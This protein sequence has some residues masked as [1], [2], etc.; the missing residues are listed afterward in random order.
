MPSIQS[1]LTTYHYCDE[2]VPRYNLKHLTRV[3]AIMPNSNLPDTQFQD[4]KLYKGEQ[5]PSVSVWLI[6]KRLKQMMVVRST[7]IESYMLRA[8][9]FVLGSE[10]VKI[11]VKVKN[12]LKA[13]TENNQEVLWCRNTYNFESVMIEDGYAI[14]SRFVMAKDLPSS[15]ITIAGK[16]LRIEHKKSNFVFYSSVEPDDLKDL[17]IRRL[18]RL[19]ASVKNQGWQNQDTV[20]CFL[21]RFTKHVMKDRELNRPFVTSI[22]DMEY[23]MPHVSYVRIKNTDDSIKWLERKGFKRRGFTQQKEMH[24]TS[25]EVVA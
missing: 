8:K 6:N 12:F 15:R 18:L 10:S 3:R 2:I 1:F 21:E 5:I 23:N 14:V 13:T 25:Q 9:S 17:M 11:G 16:V 24:D 22:V 4:L 19:V 20:V 7:N